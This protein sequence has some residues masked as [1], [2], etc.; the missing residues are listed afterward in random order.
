NEE[1]S[2]ESEKP[3]TT[4]PPRRVDTVKSSVVGLGRKVR[5]LPF[6]TF[7]AVR[8]TGGLRPRTDNQESLIAAGLTIEGKIK[9][10]GHIRIA[11]RFKGD[12]QVEGDLTIEPGAHISSELRA[13]NIVVRGEVNGNIHASFKVELMETAVLVG[14]LK[15][16]TLTV[17][18]G[19]RMRGKV[20]CGLQGHEEELV[21]A[22][23]RGVT[24]A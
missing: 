2:V 21:A 5:S 19:S 9:G 22:T 1:F 16:S 6:F 7:P 24:N 13:E 18:A 4:Q 8:L 20:E 12:V 3:D 15:A 10:S 14:D 23:E 11:G 17:A